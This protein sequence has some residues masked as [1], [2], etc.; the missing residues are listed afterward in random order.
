ML[1]RRSPQHLDGHGR[2]AAR[3]SRQLDTGVR[4]MEIC[5]CVSL[6]GDFKESIV[7]HLVGDEE[8]TVSCSA[9]LILLLFD[10]PPAELAQR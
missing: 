4:S 1:Q 3:S 6:A 7:L 8:N 2:A 10:K 5:S 9:T